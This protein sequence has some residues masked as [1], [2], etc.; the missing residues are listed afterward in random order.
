MLG[1]CDEEGAMVP[2]NVG[3]LDSDGALDPP[4][5]GPEEVLGSIEGSNDKVTDGCVD[6]LAVFSADG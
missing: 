3:E 4:D 6:G 1:T 2:T 5:D